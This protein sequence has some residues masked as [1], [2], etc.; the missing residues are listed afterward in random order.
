MKYVIQ[1]LLSIAV[2]SA[3][4]ACGAAG[5]LDATVSDSKG[6]PLDIAIWYPSDA[7]AHEVAM[8]PIRQSVAIGGPV[9]GSHLPLIVV[10]HGTGGYK[11]SHFDTAIALADAGYVVAAVTHTGDNYRD[12]S[13]SVFIM[14]RPRHITRVIDYMLNDWSGKDV[15]DADQVGM[16]GHSAGGFTTLISIGGQPDFS[17]IQPF[18]VSH[19]SHFVCQLISK[20]IPEDY[21]QRTLHESTYD[22]RIKAAV[23]AAPAMGFTFSAASLVGVHIPVQLWRAEQDQ[24]LPSPWYAQVVHDAMHGKDD[25]R[26][27]ENAGHFDF[28]APCSEAMEKIAPAICASAPGFDRTAFHAH[29]HAAMIDFFK[30]GLH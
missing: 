5:Y 27:V 21:I 8:G 3:S 7:P 10:S 15:L 4:V 20:G 6:E 26:V 28:L 13:R 19:A 9:K 11:L 17:T 1:L 18:C 29:F 14:D 16:F 25:Y 30:S 23:V 12:T 24:I 22:S 2:F